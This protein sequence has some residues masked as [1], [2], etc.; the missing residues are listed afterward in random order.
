MCRNELHAV[1]SESVNQ[2]HTDKLSKATKKIYLLKQLKRAGVS[3]AQLLHFYTT[4]SSP[5]LASL[6]YKNTDRRQ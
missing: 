5:S 3:Q 4:V 6:V 2:L 1:A